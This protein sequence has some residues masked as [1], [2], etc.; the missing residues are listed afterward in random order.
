MCHLV[1]ILDCDPV[2]M[3]KQLRY[4]KGLG[5]LKSERRAQWILYQLADPGHPVLAENLKCLQDSASEE[6]YF[7]Q[8]LKKREAL[9]MRLRGEF[10]G[11]TQAVLSEQR[12]TI[13]DVRS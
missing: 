2:K 12:A 11:C 13:E 9:I 3:S 10:S 5:M 4:M 1:E 6:L 8:D 7:R